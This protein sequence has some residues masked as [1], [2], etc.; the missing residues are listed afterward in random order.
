MNMNV[1]SSINIDKL[2]LKDKE[3]VLKNELS[4][5]IKQELYD[6][7]ENYNYKNDLNIDF[8]NGLFDSDG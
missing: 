4:S 3:R 6:Y 7:I 1:K 8:I 5:E 2:S